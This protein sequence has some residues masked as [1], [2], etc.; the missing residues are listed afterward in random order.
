MRTDRRNAVQLA[1][2]HRAGELTTAWGP[3]RSQETM[4]DL[5]RACDAAVDLLRRKG[6]SISSMLLNCGRAHSGKKTSGARHLLGVS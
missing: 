6:R 2:L 3:D 1:G 4:R 5:V